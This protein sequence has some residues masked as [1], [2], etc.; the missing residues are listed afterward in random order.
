MVAVDLAAHRKECLVQRRVVV[1]PHRP[2]DRILAEQIEVT[3]RQNET[4]AWEVRV[5]DPA[6]IFHHYFCN[7][8][9][10]HIQLWQP[11]YGISVLTPSRNTGCNFE[12]FPI[13]DWK[14][15]TPDYSKLQN[16][17]KNYLA[18]TLP[19]E[20]RVQQLVDYYTSQP[21]AANISEFSVP[22]SV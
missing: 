20:K 9:M 19:T 6:G 22:T 10:L 15:A 18:V 14:F 8:E 21:F 12:A 16:E 13:R 1:R 7:R 5:F 11:H 17:L 4:L 2:E 3:D